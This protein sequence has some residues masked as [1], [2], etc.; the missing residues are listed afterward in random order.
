V[1]QHFLLSAKARNLSL[2]VIMRMSDA[3][4]HSRFQAIRWAD[5]GGEPFCPRCEFTG[6]YTYAARRIWKCK[7]CGHQFSVR[8]GTIFASRKL[9]IRDYLAAICIFVNAVKG[10]SCKSAPKW[11]PSKPQPNSLI[12]IDESMFL[13]RFH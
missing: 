6:I 12:L 2:T 9:P 11:A 7:E 1:S 8:S 13:L 4:A 3:E 10:V 5:N